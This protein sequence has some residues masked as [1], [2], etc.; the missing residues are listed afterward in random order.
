MAKT[1]EYLR[2]KRNSRKEELIKIKGGSCEVCGYSK[3]ASALV[4]HHKYEKKKIFN[5][6]GKNLTKKTWNELLSEVK[7][8]YLLCAN[9]HAELHDKEG[10][11]HENGKRTSKMPRKI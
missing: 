7:K 9:C 3:S 6:S 5:I 2:D 1:G 10:W 8:C 11:I 4:F